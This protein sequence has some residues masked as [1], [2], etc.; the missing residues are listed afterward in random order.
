MRLR[1]PK[2]NPKPKNKINWHKFIDS[3][4]KNEC[5]QKL[6]DELAN[7]ADMGYEEFGKYAMF[8]KN[9]A[10]EIADTNN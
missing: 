5:N 4:V 3:D 2:K 6:K 10:F 7:C 8:A 9:V 1:G